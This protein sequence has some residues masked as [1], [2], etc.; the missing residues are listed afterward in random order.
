MATRPLTQITERLGESAEHLAQLISPAAS[1][2]TDPP[3]SEAPRHQP[4]DEHA[5]DADGAPLLMLRKASVAAVA[6]VSAAVSVATA[7][8]RLSGDREV[9]G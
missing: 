1:A 8:T 6:S 3:M 2:T 4:R 9:L 7:R 5:D